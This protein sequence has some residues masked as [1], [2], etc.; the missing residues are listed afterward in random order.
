MQVGKKMRLFGLSALITVAALLVSCH[1]PTPM[2]R[3]AENPAMFQSLSPEHQMMVQSGRICTGMNRDAVM[4]AWGKPADPPITGQK[5]GQSFE[6]WRYMGQ[7]PV[8]TDHI[9]FEMGAYRH[10]HHWHHGY[11]PYHETDVTYIPVEVAEVTFVNG[12]VTEWTSAR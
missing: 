10:H 7:K 3:I 4:L 12:R 2:D 11:Y 6:I 5:D 9:G 8:F 1:T